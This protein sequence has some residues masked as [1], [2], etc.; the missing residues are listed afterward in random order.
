MRFYLL[1]FTLFFGMEVVAQEILT[2]LQVNPVVREKAREQSRLKDLPFGLDTIPVSLPFFDDFSADQVF[3]S[4]ERWIDRYA[5]V[6]TDI[7]VYPINLGA[8]TLDAINDSGFLYR[9]AVF[10][11]Q[12]FIADFLTSRYIR[13]DSIFTPVP[14]KL[15]LADSVYLSFYYQPQGRGLALETTDSLVLQFLVKPAFD[16]ITPTDTIP[17]PD[18][19]EKIWITK[20]MPLD[21]FFMTNNRYFVQAM[22]PITDTAKFFKKTFRFRFFN[23]VSLASSLEPSWAS[24][25]DQWNMDNVYLNLGRNRYDTVYP[26]VRFIERAPSL[27]SN[28]EAMPY[29]QYCNDPTNEV[30]DTLDILIS[31]RATQQR[32]CSYNYYVT[33]PGGSFT[34]NYPGGDYSIKPFYTDGYVTYGPFAHPPVSFIFP[35]SQADSASFYMKHVISDKTPGST[36]GDTI[37]AYQRFRNYYAYDDGTPEAGY[38]LTPAWSK[39]AYRFRLNKS[40]DTLR[41][42]QFYFNRTLEDNNQQWF[43]LCVWNDNAGKPGDTIHSELV[44]PW[45]SDSLNQFV[46]YHLSEPIRLTGTFYVGWIQTTSDNLNV[47]FDRYNNHQN[48]IY[49]NATGQ[50]YTSSFSGSLMIRPII[51]KPIPIGIEEVHS[52]NL[53]MQLFPNPNSAGTLHIRIPALENQREKEFY[54]LTIFNFLGS[55]IFT[56]PY[57]EAIDISALPNG[58]YLL[59]LRDKNGLRKGIGKFIR[60]H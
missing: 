13:L 44:L 14:R 51:G 9:N 45:F 11:P 39:L 20:G 59:E 22:I 43:Y 16:S 3:P 8:V 29:T 34:K 58:I 1:L 7:P 4:S 26:E 46:T 48:E 57:R 28:Y 27:L 32:S 10:G 38:G 40:P 49:Y 60:S 55:K 23:Y 47:G 5:F 56:S 15:T 53:E 36:F 54:N 21:T 31:N 42:V 35:I 6:N 30:T 25:C 33:S 41:A 17:I 24:N 37:T 18:Q 52:G 50:W 19:W 12:T 2:G